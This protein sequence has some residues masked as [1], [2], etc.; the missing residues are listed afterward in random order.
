MGERPSFWLRELSRARNS[1]P[2]VNSALAMYAGDRLGRGEVEPDA[3]VL[4][5][6]LVE[7]DGR[8]LAVLVE[9]FHPQATRGADPSPA[10]EENF[11]D[12]PVPVVK[13]RVTGG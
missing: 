11:D 5:A 7:G 3:A 2:F 13:D 12:G 9:V 10:I 4:V 8:L 6:L 1:G